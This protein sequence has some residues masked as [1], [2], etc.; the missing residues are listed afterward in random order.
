[1]HLRF[2]LFIQGF[3]PFTYDVLLSLSIY[4]GSKWFFDLLSFHRFRS[5]FLTTITLNQFTNNTNSLKV[6]EE[7]VGG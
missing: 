4:D 7:C 6:K 2:G 5:R 1:M 3:C